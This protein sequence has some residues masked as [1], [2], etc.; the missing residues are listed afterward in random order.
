MDFLSKSPRTAVGHMECN[1]VRSVS[2]PIHSYH[3]NDVMMGAI[4]SQITSLTIVYS[5]VYSD[6]DQRKHQNSASL[7]FVSPVM[8]PFDDV[9]MM[10]FE[11]LQFTYMQKCSRVINSLVIT[12]MIWPFLIVE[13]K[14]TF[15]MLTVHGQQHSFSTHE[16]VFLW[17]CQSV[18][19]RKCLDPRGTRTPNL[20]IHAECSNLSSY[21]GQTFAVPWFLILALAVLV[22]WVDGNAVYI[23]VA[24]MRWI[25][26]QI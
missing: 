12:Y 6:A 21:Q 10:A 24:S 9:I 15:E 26:Q 19:D 1:I 23:F 18:W 13:V 16:R 4:A 8:F 11:L 3:H 20:R 25:Y 2:P 17:K 7:A 5:I 14:L 22:N